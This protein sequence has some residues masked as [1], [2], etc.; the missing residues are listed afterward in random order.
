[1]TLLI[2]SLSLNG[3]FR[4]CIAAV[5]FLVLLISSHDANNDADPLLSVS[6]IRLVK[7]DA[8]GIVKLVSEKIRIQIW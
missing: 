5:G 4:V 2:D 3:T 7:H 8:T 1:M 6:L